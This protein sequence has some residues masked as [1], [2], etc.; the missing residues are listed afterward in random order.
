M[1]RR[2]PIFSSLEGSGRSDTDRDR[3]VWHRRYAWCPPMS[4]LVS[5][6][7]A[8][9]VLRCHAW[10]PPMSCLAPSDGAARDIGS[11]AHRV[12]GMSHAVVSP[13]DAGQ[14][15]RPIPVAV[16]GR[17]PRF[18]FSS[19]V[20]RSVASP[21]LSSRLKTNVHRLHPYPAALRCHAWCPPISRLVPSD[22]PGCPSTCDPEYQHSVRSEY[23]SS[24]EECRMRV[25]EWNPYKACFS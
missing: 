2:R 12:V 7:V 1:R 17:T 3:F 11:H 6:N 22:V 21:S 19:I 5:S 15:H 8:L 24:I 10:C 16:R 25:P 23:I 14:W 20:I 9:D 13:S 4:R 18:C